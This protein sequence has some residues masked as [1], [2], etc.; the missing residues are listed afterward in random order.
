[1]KNILF[2]TTLSLCA[3]FTH[4]SCFEGQ[5]KLLVRKYEISSNGTPY[6]FQAPVRFSPKTP[7]DAI[8]RA[9]YRGNGIPVLIK[10]ASQPEEEATRLES[11]K[12]C[13]DYDLKDSQI[14]DLTI[15]T[16]AQI[17]AEFQASTPLAKDLIGMV[18]SYDS[19]FHQATQKN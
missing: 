11:G 14:V 5:P 19:D 18:L 7:I 9:V 12:T 17:Y 4:A 6:Y 13:G 10:P 3:W 1:M 2:A 15:K 16:H 8:K